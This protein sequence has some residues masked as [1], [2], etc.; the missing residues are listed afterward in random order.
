[1]RTKQ[2]KVLRVRKKKAFNGKRCKK[3]WN[4]I[5]VIN[6]LRIREYLFDWRLKRLKAQS[7]APASTDKL[8]APIRL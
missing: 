8:F 6:I 2:I 1:M 5:I 3:S 7:S 4:E